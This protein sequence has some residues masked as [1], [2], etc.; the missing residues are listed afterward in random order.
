[1]PAGSLPAAGGLPPVGG[2]SMVPPQPLPVVGTCPPCGTGTMPSQLHAV[3]NT[4]ETRN[5]GGNVMT[6]QTATPQSQ[7][8]VPPP[9]P[10]PLPS[11][12]PAAVAAA[13]AEIAAGP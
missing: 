7:G 10:S 1:M 5:I 4:W 9:I 3:P 2:L 13:A 12:I 8:P 6:P 11:T